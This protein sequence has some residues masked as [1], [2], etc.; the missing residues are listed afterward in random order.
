MTEFYI[1]LLTGIAFFGSVS[2]YLNYKPH[3]YQVPDIEVPGKMKWV[4][5]KA[6]MAVNYVKLIV[7][8]S[9]WIAAVTTQL[10]LFP[11]VHS[12]LKN[13]FGL[14]PAILAASTIISLVFGGVIDGGVR[15]F[16][17]IVADGYL[18]KSKHNEKIRRRALYSTRIITVLTFIFALSSMLFSYLGPKIVVPTMESEKIDITVIQDKSFERHQERIAMYDKAIRSQ[19]ILLAAED[20]KI[21][22]LWPVYYGR[23]IEGVTEGYN[24]PAWLER[25]R[26][27]SRISD[28]AKISESIKEAEQKKTEEIQSYSAY[29]QDAVSEAREINDKKEAVDD[30]VQGFSLNFLRAIGPGGTLL[31][32]LFL[33]VLS[34]WGYSTAQQ[35]Q[36][37]PAQHT[38]LD[39][40]QIRYTARRDDLMDEVNADDEDFELRYNEDTGR[41]E[42]KYLSKEGEVF[43]DKQWLKG[44]L[45]ANKYRKREK[46]ESGQDTSTQDENINNLTMLINVIEQKEKEA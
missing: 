45:R 43:K 25:K 18:R 26:K 6:P 22:S 8:F 34:L 20:K 23:A 42:I 5:S 37:R 32:I 14:N 33:I 24:Y 41:W 4:K 39:G 40:G 17:P 12:A 35:I 1:P 11:S 10:I 30:I 28:Y 2:L 3:K 29:E 13:E 16:V 21:K 27:D 38:Y 44:Q 19:K 15:V 31:E 36:I 9:F 46:E 7:E